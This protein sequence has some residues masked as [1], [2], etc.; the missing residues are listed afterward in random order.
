M[1]YSCAH[2]HIQQTPV[3]VLEIEWY[4]KDPVLG[5]LQPNEGDKQ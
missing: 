2:L 5:R 4:T 3:P 1:I